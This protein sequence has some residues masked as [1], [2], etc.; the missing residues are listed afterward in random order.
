MATTWRTVR[1]FISSTFLDMQT[2]RD[3]LVRFVFPRLRE[4]LSR[5]C[6][7]FI[8]IDLRWGVTSEENFTAICREVIDSCRPRFICILGGRYGWR[9]GAA[10]HSITADEVRYA[11][12][13]GGGPKRHCSFYFRAP[14]ATSA[15]IETVKGE[16]REIPG[17]ENERLLVEL[18]EAITAA[19]YDPYVYS[20]RWSEREGCLTGLEAFGARIYADLVSSIESELG[21]PEVLEGDIFNDED[22]AVDSF[23]EASVSSYVLGSRDVILSHLSLFA[24]SQRAPNLLVVSGFS[25]SGKSALLARLARDHAVAHPSV[26]IVR[27]FVGIGVNSADFQFALGRLLHAFSAR[28]GVPDNAPSDYDELVRRLQH[29]VREFGASARS[30]ILIDGLDEFRGA[31]FSGREF[32]RIVGGFPPTVR[33]VGSCTDGSTLETIRTYCTMEEL[34]L[35][36]LTRADARAIVEAF[37]GP[38]RKRLEEEQLSMLIA[39]QDSD[40]P[41]YL[42]ASLEELRTLGSP[43]EVTRTI[44]ELPEKVGQLFRWI[45]GRL[46]TDPGFRDIEGRSVAASLVGQFVSLVGASP[47]G[48]TPRELTDLI[49]RGDPLGNVSA[50]ERLLRPY[51]MWRA[52]RLDFFHRQLREVVEVDYL[53]ELK[54]YIRSNS[55]IFGL[56]EHQFTVAV[57]R[58]QS[59]PAF[60]LDRL[61]YHACEADM[62][63]KSESLRHQ[64]MQLEPFAIQEITAHNCTVQLPTDPIRHLLIPRNSPYGWFCVPLRA[65]FLPRAGEN[66]VRVYEDGVLQGTGLL[67]N[68]LAQYRQVEVDIQYDRD[69]IIEI[70]WRYSGGGCFGRLQL[71]GNE[72]N[73]EAQQ[74]H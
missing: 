53:G 4:E 66:G 38:L 24:A 10:A 50:V 48:L 8:D 58:A 28:M 25:G 40:L 7:R 69:R 45:L 37:L 22:A 60:D 65:T 59:L 34:R 74:W 42:A 33:I 6:I 30:M 44:L 17:S 54:D 41:L 55:A 39:K 56:L 23:V 73:L 2:E 71:S 31:R 19:R 15:M 12:L 52:G 43:H 13:D 46:A 51:L 32:S 9:P 36:P 70:R 35:G 63:E 14:S 49:D 29:R 62:F 27:H 72:Q 47:W 5:R 21:A 18:K 16:Y 61:S 3:H 57:K 67:P 1:C 20:A 64:R 68:D 26:L 11:A